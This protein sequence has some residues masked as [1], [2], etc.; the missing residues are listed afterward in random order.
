VPPI[1][2]SIA[3]TPLWVWAL[4][5]FLLY[6]GI[7]AVQP[8]A[9]PLW[10]IAILPTVFFVWGLWSLYAMHAF[11]AQRI[12]PWAAAPAAG[13][14]I[15]IAGLHPIRTDKAGMTV[16]SAARFAPP[17]AALRAGSTCSAIRTMERR[18]RSRSSQSLPA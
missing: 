3:N 11:T 6:L 4:L 17:I 10:R 12:S 2:Q 15:G 7:R 13:I 9:A 18:P 14:G 16:H 8:S 1:L 5:A